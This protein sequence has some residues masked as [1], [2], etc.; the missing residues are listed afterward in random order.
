[1]WECLKGIR[2]V[3]LDN[4]I[5]KY[6]DIH[7]SNN[8]ANSIG[9]RVQDIHGRDKPFRES[10]VVILGLIELGGLFSKNGEDGFGGVTG[11]K[12]GKERVRG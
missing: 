3:R 1:M 9:K 7:K 12:P 8:P 2:Y 11:L 4:I 6:A 10:I 5:R